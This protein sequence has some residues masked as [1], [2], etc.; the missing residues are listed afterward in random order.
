[1]YMYSNDEVTFTFC[2]SFRRIIA[3]DAHSDECM[4]SGNILLHSGELLKAGIT[5]HSIFI[6][7]IPKGWLLF[8][9]EVPLSEKSLEIMLTFYIDI[10]IDFYIFSIEES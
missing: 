8:M 1:M 3:T 10:D 4:K 5:L 6:Y 7:L 2:C 9:L